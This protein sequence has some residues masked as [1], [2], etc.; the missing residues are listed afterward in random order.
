MQ[1]LD[2]EN[3]HNE[4]LFLLEEFLGE[5]RKQ[6]SSKG[7]VTF[8][9]PS[10]SAS[11]GVD[12]DGKGNLEINYDLGVYHCWACAE[13]DGT[14]GKIYGLVKKFA[15]NDILKR[16]I[17]S[18]FIFNGDYYANKPIVEKKE[19]LKLP[20]EYFSLTGKQNSNIGGFK[21]AFA[22]LYN[23]GVTDDIIEKY[24][25]GFCLFGKYGNR[26]VIPSYDINGDLNYFVT[27]T[28][29]KH[30]KNFKYINPQVD[31][32]KIIFN[33]KKIDWNKPIFL[34]EG[35]FDHIVIP[36][37]IPLLGKKLYDLLFNKLYFNANNLI[38]IILDPDAYEDAVKIFNK[39]NS[40]RL[41]KKI[42]LNL[43]PNDCDVSSFNQ[44]YGRME[45]K[46][47]VSTKN[48]RLN[49]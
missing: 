12:Y 36:N 28:I 23:R 6:Y 37:S 32:T 39:L 8:D 43:L 19:V 9:C 7:Q 35:A 27:R 45:L 15:D 17:K 38:I 24:N 34:V 46:K 10:C 29:H 26:I 44:K 4:L 25:I 18:K 48:Y 40:G 22:Y 30:V 20:D 5:P 11:K 14:K 3:K 31:K 47:W 33:E 21:H 2:L 16:F 1:D 42:L 13:T 41:R 49:D